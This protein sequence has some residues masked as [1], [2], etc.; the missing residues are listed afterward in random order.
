MF[1]RGFKEEK[2]QRA[3]IPEEDPII[4]D[5]FVEWLYQDRISKFDMALS[6]ETSGPFIDRI[7]LY[8]YGV[9]ICLPELQDFAMSNIM[10]RYVTHRRDPSFQAIIL[11][12]KVARAASPL[13]E[14]MAKTLVQLIG[15]DDTSAY[16]TKTAA[17]IVMETPDLVRDMIRIT[18]VYNKNPDMQGVRPWTLPKCEFHAHPP[19]AECAYKGDV[20]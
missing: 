1:K 9:K 10:S 8:E 2:E 3:T 19:G 17:D 11:A 15:S 12:Y 14:F 13:R 16:A 5:M 4:F 20:L 7:K 6:T 18:G